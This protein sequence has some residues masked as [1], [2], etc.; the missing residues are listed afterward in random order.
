MTK[1]KLNEFAVD[2]CFDER[3][4]EI[5]ND[6]FK[7]NI[8]PIQEKVQI[9]KEYNQQ[10]NPNLRQSVVISDMEVSRLED[11]EDKKDA[12]EI[13]NAY[14][15]CAKN[16]KSKVF[17]LDHN[18]YHLGRNIKEF[19]C[20]NPEFSAQ[21]FDIMDKNLI[22]V[23]VIDPIRSCMSRDNSLMDKGFA[24]IHKSADA[25]CAK[26]SDNKKAAQQLNLVFADL[27]NFYGRLESVDTIDKIT[28]YFSEFEHQMDRKFCNL[29]YICSGVASSEYHKNNPEKYEKMEIL[30]KSFDKWEKGKEPFKDIYERETKRSSFI[31]KVE[32]KVVARSRDK[33]ELY[34]GND[35]VGLL[36]RVARKDDYLE[37][38]ENG[39]SGDKDVI[40]RNKILM[41]A[42]KES[43]NE[44]KQ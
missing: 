6:G 12:Q 9:A 44:G 2:V 15:K 1:S 13:L 43:K 14:D 36:N 5:S 8:L 28:S 30:S 37:F 34:L 21:A 17:N 40:A 38:K 32:Q 27:Y 11:I 4:M 3:K 16:L 18:K 19:V 41:Q 24:A 20:G 10:K 35:D 7:L 42:R 26:A 25:I 31:N 29:E 39:K 22:D 33:G 23:D